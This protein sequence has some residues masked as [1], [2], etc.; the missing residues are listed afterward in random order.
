MLGVEGCV[1][2]ISPCCKK[3]IVSRFHFLHSGYIMTTFWPHFSL[4]GLV[5]YLSRFIGVEEHIS[6]PLTLMWNRHFML[7][8]ANPCSTLILDIIYLR[9]SL[10]RYIGEEHYCCEKNCLNRESA[11]RQ[12][13]TQFTSSKFQNKF[14][15]SHIRFKFQSPVSKHYATSLGSILYANSFFFL[16]FRFSAL[17]VNWYS[18]SERLCLY[19][20]F[21]KHAPFPTWKQRL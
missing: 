19:T 17:W 10:I 7:P 4:L 2:E 21:L 5:T 20:V 14:R 1:T 6:P 3:K 13:I 9:S 18:I 15:A 8:G 12:Q 16:F 11:K